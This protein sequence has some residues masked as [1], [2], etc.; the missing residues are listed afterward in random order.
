MLVSVQA[1]G[2]VFPYQGIL[3][4]FDSFLLVGLGVREALYLAGVATKEAVEVGTN[5][6]TLRLLEV[7]ALGA[8]CLRGSHI[9]IRSVAEAAISLVWFVANR[10]A[11]VCTSICIP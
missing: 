9:S 8:S 11:A 6:V 1:R 7:V 4:P 3:L 2:V 10:L 5:F